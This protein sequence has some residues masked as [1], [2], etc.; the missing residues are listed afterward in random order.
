MTER[1]NRGRFASEHADAD[2]VAAVRDREP[3]AT[4]EVADELGVARQSADVRLRKLADAGQVSRKKIGAAAVWWV[5]ENADTPAG[6]DPDDAFWSAAP[7][8][9]TEPTDAA[10]IDEHLADALADE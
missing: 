3:A 4:S 10:K 7:S 2:V 9:S 8:S 6:V 1:D 5:P